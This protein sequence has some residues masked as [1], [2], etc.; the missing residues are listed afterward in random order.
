VLVF[1]VWYDRGYLFFSGRFCF[2]I[3][4]WSDDQPAERRE[5]RGDVPEGEHQ[6]LPHGGGFSQERTWF[7]G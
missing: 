5:R 1:I 6:H 3:N 2:L 4:A 7:F